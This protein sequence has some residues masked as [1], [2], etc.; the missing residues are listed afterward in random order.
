MDV[1][2]VVIVG[3]GPAGSSAA[4]FLAAAG[5]DVWLLESRT[6]PRTKPCGDGIGPRAMLMLKEMG[7]AGWLETGGY[8]RIERMRLIS[9]SGRSIVSD[10]S[11]HDFPVP[12]GYVVRR[13]VFDEK[14]VRHAQAA[15]ANLLE[16]WRAESCILEEGRAVGVRGTHRGE[17]AEIRARLVVAAD[18]STGM[19]SRHFG[20]DIGSVQAV[21]FRSYADFS[22]ELDNCANIYFSDRLP[23]GYAWVFPLSKTQANIGIGTLGADSAKVNLRAAFS[24][25]ITETT[26]PVRLDGARLESTGQGSI[27]RM[28]FGKRPLSFPGVAFT[29]DAAGLVSP[30][31]GEGISHAI[32]SS[33]ILADSLEG[34]FVD[35]E[36]I[37]RALERYS[38]EMLRNYRSYFRW[39]RFLGMLLSNPARLDRL[40]MKAQRD[41]RLAHTLTGVLSNTIHPR[42][43][44]RP[45][46][47]ARLVL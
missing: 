7:L 23:K 25:F 27:M 5:L 42:E 20:N 24:Q 34:G 6:L 37:D 39:G 29:G 40:I 43:L 41:P 8:Y 12:Y 4:Y 26:V 31:N 46:T 32:E 44:A 13:E 3:A 19:F 16:A 38:R 22:E 15:G 21:A 11:G 28:S 45:G 47:L 35:T 30:I 36:A 2:D 14:L 17:P 33:R 18:G 10:T 9:R 1:K